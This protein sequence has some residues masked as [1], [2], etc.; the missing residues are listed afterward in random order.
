MRVFCVLSVLVASLLLAGCGATVPGSNTGAGSDSK[1]NGPLSGLF[2]STGGSKGPTRPKMPMPLAQAK[3]AGGDVVAAGPEG[4]CLD[5]KTVQSRASRGFALIASCQILSGGAVGNWAEPVLITVTVGPKGALD[6]LPSPAALAQAA[7]AELLAG[8]TAPGFVAA[9]LDRGGDALLDGGDKHYWRGAFV[10]NGRLV[11]LA[12]YAPE[13][14]SYAAQQG[15][16]MLA[17]VKAQIAALSPNSAPVV[18]TQTG[19]PG[20]K[21]K[22]LFGRLFDGK[23][24]P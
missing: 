21:G 18:A 10:L 13:G 12:L 1:A 3:L 23:D 9:N 5:P 8:E 7:G 4:Y 11:G 2:T 19:T 24:L 14:S 16:G 20:K 15:G 22:S 17:R 6:D